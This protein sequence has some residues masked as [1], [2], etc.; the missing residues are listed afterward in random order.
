MG[1]ICAGV[2]GILILLWVA[3]VHCVSEESEIHANVERLNQRYDDFFH[4]RQRLEQEYQERLAGA[5]E[6][7]RQRAALAEQH[8][9]ARADYV[10][11][12]KVEKPDPRLETHWLEEQKVLRQQEELTRQRY[13]DDR[14][15]ILKA[16]KRG[17]RIPPML[18]FDLDDE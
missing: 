6:V 3:D 2:T 1:R 11:T 7:A 10:H 18:E 9:K 5:A 12:H 15:A 8:A 16:E 13:V 4:R 14:D 17:R